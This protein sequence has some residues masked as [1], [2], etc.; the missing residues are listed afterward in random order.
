MPDFTIETAWMCASNF[1][2][3]THVTGSKGDTY[4]VWWG[5]L[6][7]AC[8][9]DVGASHGWQCEC[10]GFKFR[11][12]CKHIASV[13]DQRCG[14]NAHMEP[15]MECDHDANGGPCCPECGGRVRSI[16]VAV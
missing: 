16:R 7:E 12:T 15:T 2:W 5:R 4:K 11:G 8:A 13:K 14:W 6:P 9:M 10:K 3:M 1:Y